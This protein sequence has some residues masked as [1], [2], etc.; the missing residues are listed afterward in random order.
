MLRPYQSAAVDQIRNAFYTQGHKRVLLH[1]ATG[2]GKTVVFSYIIKALSDKGIPCIMVVRGR[3]LVDQ[4][5]RRLERE[6]VPHGVRM[7]GHPR[8]QP[9]KPVQVCSIDTLRSKGSRPEASIIIIDE[10]HQATSPSYDTFLALYPDALRL[11]VTATPYNEGMSRHAD[12]VVKPVSLRTLID[13]GFLVPPRYYAPFVPNLRGVRIQSNG[14]YNQKELAAATDT[15]EIVANIVD[16][17]R[18][19]GEN[20]PT[21]AFTVRV[22]H[23]QHLAARFNSQGVPAKHLDANSQDGERRQGLADLEAGRLKVITNVGLFGTG[24]DLPF[25]S[26]IIHARATQS[27]N[28]WVQD[29]GRGTRLYPGKKDF[30][31]LDHSGNIYRHGFI[32]D[33]PEAN[34][35]DGCEKKV[36]VKGVRTCLVCYATFPSGGRCPNGCIGEV[37]DDIAGE[38]EGELKEIQTLSPE[39][40][41]MIRLKRYAKDKGLKQ[42]WVY[43]QMLAKYGEEITSKLMPRRVVPAHVR[44]RLLD[45]SLRSKGI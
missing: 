2:A 34:V 1:M 43:F 14:E 21:I 42:G 6:G 31:V 7:A 44:A 3:Q 40:L 27:Y 18:L 20:R 16:T 33:E 28:R 35:K 13:D 26:C 29:L 4:A 22:S 38:V 5:S 23:S 9:D 32:E 11:A 41:E 30:L 10:A 39:H 17:W 8:W 12:I 25:L 24:V 37:K 19:K 36:G 15:D 45:E